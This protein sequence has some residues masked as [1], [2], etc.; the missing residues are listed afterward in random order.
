[1]PM[2]LEVRPDPQSSTNLQWI[3]G[4]PGVGLS[5]RTV[6]ALVDGD[7]TLWEAAIEDHYGCIG[8]AML[9]W[10]QANVA[11][12]GTYSDAY[13][14]DWATG[15]LKHHWTLDIPYPD[16]VLPPGT[17]QLLIFDWQNVRSI[18]TTLHTTWYARYVAVDGIRLV[19]VKDNLMTVDACYDPPDFWERVT[20][21]LATGEVR[22]RIPIDA[23]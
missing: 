22:S 17:G 19:N 13:A 11:M 8:R 10:P 4:R 15:A 7:R 21:D 2:Q 20:I 12:I 5:G 23:D 9:T 6:V 1:M 16:F 14:L 3:G 18:S